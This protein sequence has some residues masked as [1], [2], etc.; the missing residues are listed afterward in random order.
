VRVVCK[1][2]IKTNWVVTLIVMCL[3]AL[4]AGISSYNLFVF[5]QAN[6]RFIAENGLYALQEGAL[7]QLFTLCVYGLLSMVSYIVF[8]SCEKILVEKLLRFTE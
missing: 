5:F 8:K 6:F 2:L 1:Y 4:A 3:S 7:E